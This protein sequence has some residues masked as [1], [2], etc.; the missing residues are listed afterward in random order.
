ME[1]R[2]SVI[3]ALTMA[4]MTAGTF[5]VGGCA[6]WPSS[7]SNGLLYTNVTK[8]VAVLQ[9]DAAAVR[10]GEAC[11]IG[12]FGL[13]ASGNSSI[14]AA[15]SSV[16]ITNITMVEERYRQYLLGAYSKYCVVVSGT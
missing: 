8:P 5:S 3:K 7:G 12:L 11:S 10:Q 1:I 14:S 9:S 15:R 13:F 4:A 6:F 2:S 16:G